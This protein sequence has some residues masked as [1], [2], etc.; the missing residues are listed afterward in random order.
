MTDTSTP[1]VQNSQANPPGLDGEPKSVRDAYDA[2]A[3]T[4]TK[5][6]GKR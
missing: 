1:I 3:D 6:G 2:L 5:K 4:W